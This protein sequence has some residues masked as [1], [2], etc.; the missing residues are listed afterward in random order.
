M[1]FIDLETEQ[2]LHSMIH[3]LAVARTEQCSII[4]RMHIGLIL[5]ARTD[6]HVSSLA[7]VS[8]NFLVVQ[9]LTASVAQS[10]NMGV[11][12]SVDLGPDYII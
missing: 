7:S 5:T 2:G 12:F 6:T 3:A 8:C 11:S 9:G 1:G 10:I 4:F